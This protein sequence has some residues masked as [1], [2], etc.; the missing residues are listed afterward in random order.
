MVAAF[1]EAYAQTVGAGEP[2]VR[3][4]LDLVGDSFPNILNALGLPPEMWEPFR[5][6]SRRRV[7]ELSLF[8]GMLDVCRKLRRHGIP[9]AVLT[10]KD[11]ERTVEVLERLGCADLFSVLATCSDGF[12][13]KPSPAGIYRI[14][15]KL[16]V[17][18]RRICT[19]GDA[20]H[21]V[22]AANRAGAWA[23]GCAWGTAGEQTLRDAGAHLIV[24]DPKAL[25]AALDEWLGT[26]AG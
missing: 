2:P 9:L 14:A 26:A 6:A 22:V 15:E 23:I 18:P 12:D 7:G 11:R 1:R 8:D 4:F 10:G 21:D 16:R 19:V 17:P 3:S 24:H 25:M 13:A 5:A 20:A